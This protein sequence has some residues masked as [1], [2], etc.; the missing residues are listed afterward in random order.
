MG[1]ESPG[2]SANH[3]METTNRRAP[4]N[5][6]RQSYQ[7]VRLQ[8][9][10]EALLSSENSELSQETRTCEIKLTSMLLRDNRSGMSGLGRAG[11]GMVCVLIAC[12]SF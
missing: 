6:S 5:R 11:G 4:R 9:T 7:K 10:D 2:L 1:A 12:H 3:A 8:K